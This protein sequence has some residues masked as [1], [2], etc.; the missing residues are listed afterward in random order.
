MT[1]ILVVDDEPALRSQLERAARGETREVMAAESTEQALQLLQQEDFDVV[2]TDLRMEADA[3]GLSVLQAAKQKDI[4]TQVIVV[5]AYGTPEVS[6]EAMRLGAFDYIERNA[7]GT[8]VLSM[9]RSKISLA[10]KFR[11]ANL[12]DRDRS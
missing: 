12:R 11:E 2:V 7:P 5:T 6:V 3:I 10:L 1:I 8:D 4:Y 9:V